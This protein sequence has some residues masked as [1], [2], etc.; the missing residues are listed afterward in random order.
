M[1]VVYIHGATASDRSFA[2]I[3]QSIQALNP[4]YLNYNKEDSAAKNLDRMIDQLTIVD[5][6]VYY[7]THS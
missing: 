6:P 3:Q 7:I 5:K 1:Q 4:I 2:F